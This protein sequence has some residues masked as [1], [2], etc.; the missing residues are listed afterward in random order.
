M[1]GRRPADGRSQHRAPSP[2][3]HPPRATPRS[4]TW[5]PGPARHTSP[6]PH[7]PYPGFRDLQVPWPWT[8]DRPGALPSGAAGL[9]GAVPPAILSCE[10]TKD[11]GSPEQNRTQCSLAHSAE[12][13]SP[14]VY[15]LFAPGGSKPPQ[16]AQRPRGGR[17]GGGDPVQGPREPPPQIP[18]SSSGKKEKEV[19][20]KTWVNEM[21]I[22]WVNKTKKLPQS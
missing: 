6:G 10:V 19:Y 16:S 7:A 3:A 22:R 13:G 8:G 14:K 9:G 1:H 17:A 12:T 15:P 4:S 21:Y 18:Q 20:I 11:I 5:T 2:C